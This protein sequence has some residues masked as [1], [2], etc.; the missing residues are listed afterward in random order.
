MSINPL[1]GKYGFA[2]GGCPF[3][4]NYVHMNMNQGGTQ[5]EDDF[6]SLERADAEQRRWLEWL[7]EQ[8]QR[9]AQTGNR[10]FSS[11]FIPGH[12]HNLGSM[13]IQ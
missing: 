5:I 1:R 13:Q 4:R 7:A 2:V 8:V 10:D 9:A 12:R 6:W 11:R 3:L